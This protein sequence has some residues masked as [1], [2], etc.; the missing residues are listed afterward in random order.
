MMLAIYSFTLLAF[1]EFD[2]KELLSKSFLFMHK[3]FYHTLTI[4]STL[5]ILLWISTKIGLVFL[6][7]L[8]IIG[9]LSSK[10]LLRG[11]LFM[12]FSEEQKAKLFRF[13]LNILE[14]EH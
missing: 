10:V 8:P 3:R 9:I 2:T 5:F 13:T 6:L 4:L 14:E 1:I 7:I 11:G 12:Y